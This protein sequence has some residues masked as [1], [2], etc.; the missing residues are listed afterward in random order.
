LNGNGGTG[1]GTNGNG[2][3]NGSGT[4]VPPIPPTPPT[5]PTQ[6]PSTPTPPTNQ[7]PPN[8]QVP[9]NNQSPPTN[10]SPPVAN[11]NGSAGMS[12]ASYDTS[13]NIP[14]DEADATFV[15]IPLPVRTVTFTA[16]EAYSLAYA[17]EYLALDFADGVITLPPQKLHSIA[18]T[19]GADD[20][21]IEMQL[22][23]TQVENADLQLAVEIHMQ[24][25]ENSLE[26]F[27]SSVSVAIDFGCIDGLNPYKIIAL[28]ADGD[29][30]GGQFCAET[31]VFIF[32]TRVLGA[33]YVKYAQNLT[34]LVLSPSSYTFDCIASGETFVMDTTPAI[35]GGRLLLPV[36]FVAEALGADIDR[37]RAADGTQIILIT[38]GSET[39]AMPIGEIT[40]QLADLGMDVPA[41][42]Y[43]SRTMVPIRFVGNFF[44]ALVIW[45][46][47]TVQIIHL[48]L[49]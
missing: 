4:S 23:V 18:H 27:D 29:I 17:G 44:G 46:G 21:P 26:N 22:V 19:M 41:M 7:T 24:I 33:F 35:V 11:A 9:P 47:S 6:T 10:Q 28:T 37:T 13:A 3:G 1:G 16:V 40:P 25:G 30:L 34:R 8:N 20:T 31:G 42:V 36:R 5:P 45:D 15:D 39:I 43:N 2:N 48:G 32:N 14:D 49:A 12:G 38:M